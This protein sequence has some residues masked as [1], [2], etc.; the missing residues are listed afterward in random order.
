MKLAIFDL[1][2]TLLPIDSDYTWS[3][4]TCDQGWTDPDK[5]RQENEHFYAQYKARTLDMNAYVAFVTRVLQ[6]QPPQALHAIQQQYARDYIAPHILP[7]ARALLARHRDAGD[8]LVLT[9][10]TN[11][12]IAQPIGQMLGFAP[13]HILCTELQYDAQGRITGQV[14][15]T[16]NLGE[17]KLVNL[18]HWLHA[19]GL[20]WPGVDI[21]FYS[22]SMNDLPLLEKAQHPV[23]TNPDARLRAIAAERGWPVLDLFTAPEKTHP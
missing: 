17:G 6:G 9:T 3:S 18:G 16:P 5:T 10:A 23:A 4:F 21:T 2:H 7:P 13:E 14:Q 11:R 12:F 22:D 8:T 15:G 20:D 1:D 19:R